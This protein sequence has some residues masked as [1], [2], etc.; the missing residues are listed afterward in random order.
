MSSLVDQLV[1]DGGDGVLPDQ[2][3]GGTSGP[4]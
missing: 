1:I 4:R 2:L 3:L